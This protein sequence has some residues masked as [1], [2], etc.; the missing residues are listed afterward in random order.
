MT[1]SA[2]FPRFLIPV[3][4]NGCDSVSARG[5]IVWVN[6]KKVEARRTR[7]RIPLDHTSQ[8]LHAS[9]IFF[10]RNNLIFFP[11]PITC[12][13]RFCK[14]RAT[15]FWTDT[16]HRTRT[17][18]FR[19]APGSLL[20]GHFFCWICLNESTCGAVTF[21]THTKTNYSRPVPLGKCGSSDSS[22]QHGLVAFCLERQNGCRHWNLPNKIL[23]LI[24][25]HCSVSNPTAQRSRF[26]RRLIQLKPAR[27]HLLHGFSDR[28]IM[29]NFLDSAP[30]VMLE[31]AF[32]GRSAA[33]PTD[34]AWP[35]G[36]ASK[37]RPRLNQA[38]HLRNRHCKDGKTWQPKEWAA[39]K[40]NGWGTSVSRNREPRT[41]PTY[42]QIVTSPALHP[43]CALESLFCA[44]G[45]TKN[46]EWGPPECLNSA[47][48][49]MFW[50]TAE[51]EIISTNLH[52]F[53]QVL[54]VSG[55]AKKKTYTRGDCW[56][57]EHFHNH[58]SAPVWTA[59]FQWKNW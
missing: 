22:H 56:N 33:H 35:F 39:S 31:G 14:S 30:L 3:R 13:L 44:C 29:R 42:K 17:P 36:S 12:E 6:R 38:K 2:S 5:Q 53:L 11:H 50:Q 25:T 21:L 26:G 54:L 49:K 59:G 23:N 46:F 24:A 55:Q 1:F 8:I 52:V 9:S 4:D 51:D 41:W 18:I 40:L 27:M 28:L 58:G 57:V 10:S 19:L 7:R 45:P 15:A 43:F 34:K 32:A 16:R 48:K 37:E 47:K 20:N